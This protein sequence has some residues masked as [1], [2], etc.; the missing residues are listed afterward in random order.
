MY[1]IYRNWIRG[2]VDTK[3]T[4]EQLPE[5]SCDSYEE[6]HWA[7]RNKWC[8]EIHD[9]L[10]S[11]RIIR[12]RISWSW[13]VNL[14]KHWD[15]WNHPR[16]L[17]F[18]R[19]SSFL[20]QHFKLESICLYIF[21]N[22]WGTNDG[23]LISIK[24]INRKESMISVSNLDLY[25]LVGYCS[26]NKLILSLCLKII[27]TQRTHRSM[28][29]LSHHSLSKDAATNE[30]VAVTNGSGSPSTTPTGRLAFH[31]LSTTQHLQ[32][33][34][35]GQFGTLQTSAI[36]RRSP[37]NL[38]TRLAWED[39]A[40]NRTMVEN[41]MYWNIYLNCNH[42]RRKTGTWSAS[43]YRQLWRKLERL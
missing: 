3:P 14:L 22:E 20:N 43:Y 37:T 5:L 25:Y 40:A 23:L 35:E 41:S 10:I 29:T 11:C 28:T 24:K 16:K 38:N 39:I 13:M 18:R 27:Q 17:V 9:I 36:Q 8:Q 15:G 1:N 21:S 42:D 26:N 31:P 30:T 34:T 12:Y 6:S 32:L 2:L 19:K 7:R 33:C 4:Q